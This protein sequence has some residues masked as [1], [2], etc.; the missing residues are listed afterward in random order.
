MFHFPDT[1]HK[2]PLRITRM[3][4]L[5]DFYLVATASLPALGKDPATGAREEEAEQAGHRAPSSR[6]AVRAALAFA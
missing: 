5:C 1:T 4:A 2:P 3:P 6:L